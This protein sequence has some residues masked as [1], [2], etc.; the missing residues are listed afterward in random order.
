MEQ[1]FSTQIA[2]TAMTAAT[3]ARPYGTLLPT[4]GHVV[5]RDR[6][7]VIGAVKGQAGF[8]AARGTSA[9]RPPTC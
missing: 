6:R 7:G 3:T 8:A 9:W 4:S 2:M 1:M 5:D